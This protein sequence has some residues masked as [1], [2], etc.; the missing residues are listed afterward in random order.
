[1]I[2]I[3]ESI[4]RKKWEDFVLNHPEGNI[5]QT[6]AIADVYRSTKNYEPISLAA[7][8]LESG[9]IFAVLQAAIIRDAAGLVGSI[10]S[11]SIINGGPLFVYGKKGLEALEK[12]LNYYE[13]FLNN[14]AFYTLV[15]NLWD[16]ES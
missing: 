7:I 8:E 4:D 10:S 14:R 12:L 11:R 16:T 3:A 2:E 6:C 1:M 5:F 13:K 15:R 9:E